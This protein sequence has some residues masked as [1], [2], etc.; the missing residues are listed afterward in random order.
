MLSLRKHTAALLSL[1]KHFARN[2]STAPNVTTVAV[3]SPPEN[4]A[5]RAMPTGDA[6]LRFLVGN[7]A[8]ELLALPELAEAEALLFVPPGNPA[9]LGDVFAAAPRVRWCHSFFAGVDALQPFVKAHLQAKRVL[10]AAAGGAEVEVDVPLTNGKGAFSDSLA[11]WVMT[12]ALH[13]NKQVPRVLANRGARVWDKFVMGTLAGK[14]I[15]L[16][17]FGHIGQTTARMAKSGFGMRVI[18]CRRGADAPDASVGGLADHVYGI[19]E[20]ARLFAESDFVVCALPGTAETADFCGAAEFGAMK[21]S[22]VFISI[23]RGLAVDEAALA[24]ALLA[25]RIAGAALDVFKVEPLPQESK[26][27]ECDNLVLTAHNADFTEDYF[28]LGWSVWRANLD[29]IRAGT[30]VVTPVSKTAGY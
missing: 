15:G 19:E 23:G 17:G 8:A 12:A 24:E 4:P 5:L 18:A 20:R 10:P 26:L 14:T 21:E 9:I 16:V 28:E 13:F 22:G 11:E 3:V 25:K 29:G 7:T 30:G 2:M 27:W 1:G 6:S